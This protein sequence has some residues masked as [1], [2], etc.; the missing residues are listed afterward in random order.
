MEAGDERGNVK[1]VF[2]VL[3]AIREKN[4]SLLECPICREAYHIDPA[5]ED[6]KDIE[7]AAQKEVVAIY[8]SCD[9]HKIKH[10]V[11][12]G[13]NFGGQ[14]LRLLEPPSWVKNANQT[15]K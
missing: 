5:S 8:C 4:P 10:K 15:M 6:W 9:E 2:R 13:T 12:V 3:N 11:G 7:A 1:D 14:F